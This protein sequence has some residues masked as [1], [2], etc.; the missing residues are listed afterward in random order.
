M[1]CRVHL[2]RLYMAFFQKCHLIFLY[3]RSNSPPGLDKVTDWPI[4]R[5]VMTVTVTVTDDRRSWPMFIG[6][7][8]DRRSILDRSTD[9]LTGSSV[10]IC[11]KMA[12]QIIR[13]VELLNFDKRHTLLYVRHERPKHEIWWNCIARF[14]KLIFFRAPKITT[15]I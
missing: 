1:Q 12:V 11:P 4:D 2:F 5:S 14:G 3:N 15:I 10:L 13:R 6:Q 7:F 9:I 8:F